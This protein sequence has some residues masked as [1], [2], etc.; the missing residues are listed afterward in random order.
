MFISLGWNSDAISV[1]FPDRKYIVSEQV[2]TLEQWLHN[3]YS[4]NIMGSRM[5]LGLTWL[6]MPFRNKNVA[7]RKQ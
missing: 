4:R 6:Q 3:S 1:S 7:K 5:D 2:S